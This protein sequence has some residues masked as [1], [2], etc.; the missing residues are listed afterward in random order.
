MFNDALLAKQTWRL[1]SNTDSLLHKVFK[2]KFFPHSSILEAKE[3][4]AGSYAWKSILKGRDV[5]LDGACG[6]VGD[7]RSIKIWQHR[8]LP[9]KHPP[10]INSSILDSM[11]E[12]TVD[13]LIIPE[14][15]TWNHEMIDGIFAPQEADLIKKKKKKSLSKTSSN[16]FGVLADG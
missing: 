15:R 6:R 13:S 4:S 8:W 10:K 9:I 12:A 14:T 16:R 2:A 3:S 7:G 5:I 11:A 1:L